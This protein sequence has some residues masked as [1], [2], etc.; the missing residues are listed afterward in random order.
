MTLL[1]FA[2]LTLAAALGIAIGFERQWNQGMAGLRT[3]SLVAFGAACFVTLGRLTEVDHTPVRMASLIVS[4]IGFLGAGV[5]FREGASV[6]GLNTAATLWCSGACGALAGSGLVPE[7]VYGALGV[8][9]INL[10]LRPLRNAIAR[11]APHPSDVETDYRIEIACAAPAEA[12]LRAL[13]LA[14]SLQS[15]LG[16]KALHSEKDG[17]AVRIVAELAAH[18]R[19]DAAVETVASR[20]GVEDGVASVRWSIAAASPAAET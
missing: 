6:R 2:N 12:N 20:L 17:D 15:G 14:N 19:L 18:S 9:A 10:G 8:I 11:W 13:L 4:G 16:L 1:T 3:N 7:A 5:I